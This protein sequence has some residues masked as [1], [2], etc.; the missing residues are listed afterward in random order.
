[1]LQRKEQLS[2]AMAARPMRAA[3]RDMA[4]SA[5]IRLNEPAWQALQVARTSQQT[6]HRS[7]KAQRLLPLQQHKTAAASHS[8]AQAPRRVV[9]RKR[10]L[11]G[12]RRSADARISC[13]RCPR[14]HV[15]AADAPAA[16]ALPGW[17]LAARGGSGR[18]Q[19]SQRGEEGASRR[20]PSRRGRWR[21][22]RG[23]RAEF[24]A[25]K[26]QD[27]GRK[28]GCLIMR[29][30]RAGGTWRRK[31]RRKQRRKQMMRRW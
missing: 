5:A 17:Q 13:T 22:R 26:G 6:Q 1:M 23:A 8:A 18:A 12:C 3:R 20:Y 7:G 15:P 24:L 9:G 10:V 19:G 11:A 4:D 28:A 21:R 2:H 30:V 25:L 16:A 14:A 27:V 29:Y 31:R